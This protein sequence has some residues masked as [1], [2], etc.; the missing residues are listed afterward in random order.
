MGI[1]R[2]DIPPFRLICVQA[3]IP[4]GY[5]HSRPED[6]CRCA[7]WEECRK[8]QG[9]V[10]GRAPRV[11]LTLHGPGLPVKRNPGADSRAR[12]CGAPRLMFPQIACVARWW[13]NTVT[14]G[15]SALGEKVHEIPNYYCQL[16]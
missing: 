12:S 10:W 7:E 11:A 1:L 9:A 8:C 4:W 14:I 6:A 16:K 15:Q 13:T 5:G 3:H 2:P